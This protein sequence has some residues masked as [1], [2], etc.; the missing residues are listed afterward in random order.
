MQPDTTNTKYYQLTASEFDWEVSDNKII[1]AWG[2]NNSVPG[3]V[4]R[5]KKGET[6]SILKLRMNLQEPT[7]VHW[8]GI[9][10]PSSMDGH[11]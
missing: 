7:V 9:R 1:K 5:A 2:F 11:G 8:H 6:L 4:L 10:F 3:P